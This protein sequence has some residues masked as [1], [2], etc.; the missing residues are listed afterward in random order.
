M[1]LGR[2]GL[3]GSYAEQDEYGWA[4]AAGDFNSDGFD[5]LATGIPQREG[6]GA[7]LVVYGSPFSLIFGNHQFFD[8]G[9]FGELPEIGD[10]FGRALAVGDFNDD[11]YADLAMGAPGEDG[12]LPSQANSGQVI[13]SYGSTAGLLTQGAPWLSED[14]IWGVG[15]EL[16]DRFGSALTSG[17]FDADG[18][19]DLVVGTAGESTAF[20][21]P[22]SG[23][24]TVIRGGFLGLAGRPARQLLPHAF[25]I[26]LIA[27]R[28]GESDEGAEY[29]EALATGDFD[30]NGFPDL[31]I[32][33][34]SR[35]LFP[36]AS[37]GAVA[38][39]YGQL[40]LDGFESADPYEWS[41]VAP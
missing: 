35:M 31:A 18:Y 3:P 21:G 6:K 16:Q 38:V 41:V 23:A 34:P 12:A 9:S 20:G 13:V 1:Q 37:V 15:S 33:A 22:G 4:V 27:Q 17:D 30:G 8:Q 32:G 7:V 5:D 28:P 11:G 36:S 26:G 39:I 40:F 25:P 2:E 19:D 24:A 29:G 14:G 10:D